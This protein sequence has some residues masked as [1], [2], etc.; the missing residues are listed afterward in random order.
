L[1][2]IYRKIAAAGRNVQYGRIDKENCEDWEDATWEE[3]AKPE[4][5]KFVKIVFG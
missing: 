3:K 2:R 5:K 1:G 4:D